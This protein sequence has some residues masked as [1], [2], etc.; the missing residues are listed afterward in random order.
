M[1]WEK[2]GVAEDLVKDEVDYFAS[3]S[4]LFSHMEWLWW[5]EKEM[6]QLRLCAPINLVK[7]LKIKDLIYSI[8]LLKKT[9]TED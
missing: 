6:D 7:E 3:T 1:L 4:L 5:G 2:Y 9:S 8:Q